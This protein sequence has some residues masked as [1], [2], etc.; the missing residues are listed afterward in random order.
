LRDDLND[1]RILVLGEFVDRPAPERDRDEQQQDGFHAGDR[2]FDVARGVAFDAGVI[3]FG[4]ARA[5]EAE[6]DEREVR[7][8]ADE[9][10]DHQ[11]V[12]VNDQVVHAL[13]VFRRERWQLQQF[14]HH[15][16]L[17]FEDLLA[18]NT[19]NEATLASTVTTTPSRLRMP[20]FMPWAIDESDAP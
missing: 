8:P 5:V 1:G 17:S 19:K 10:R 3:G 16:S 4:I 6:E 7:D 11:P 9:Q 18:M 15:G 12:N 14:F 13:A 20:A 2:E